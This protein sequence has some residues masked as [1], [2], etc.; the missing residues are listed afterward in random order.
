M[1][2][3]RIAYDWPEPWAGLA[4]HPYE[5][6]VAQAKRGHEITVFAGK[7]PKS[8]HM[9]VPEGVTVKGFIREPVKGSLAFT[10]SLLLF[11]YYLNWRR[12]N[13]PDLIHI[14]GHFA[15]WILGYRRL[16]RKLHPS[17][18]ELTIPLVAHFHNTVEGRKRKLQAKGSTISWV[19]KYISWPLA[20]RSDK[21]AIQEANAYIFVSE[22]LKNEAIEFYG[23]D[24]VKCF[25]I[26]TGVN[27]SL[28][29]LVSGEEKEKTR[30][31]L[32]LDIEDI[33]LLN[34]GMQV[35]RKNTLN[36]VL[37]LNHLPPHYKVM[38]IGPGDSEYLT[39]IDDAIANNNLQG[40]VIRGGYMPYPQM[41]IALQADDV[42]VLHS[43]F[44]GLPK[45]VL[46]A[47]SCGVPVLASGFKIQDQVSGLA[48]LPDTSPEAIASAVTQL[49][50]DPP[51]VDR[52]YVRLHYSWDTRASELDS[53]YNQ[54]LRH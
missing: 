41:P 8:G 19:S 38:L 36:L 50:A 47:L 2:I 28:F 6:T 53:V 35:R 44:E 45:A 33:V 26:R 25:V 49:L 9:L 27:V 15:L 23:A 24:P 29:K 54:L 13:R 39:E 3:L 46:E 40:R 18:A 1:K 21:W 34:Y 14:H 5:L 31:D 22:G 4:P 48:Y 52:T 30:R 7:W 32:G 10:T 43:S 51:N 16:L 42:L 37:A 11:V 12:T 17:S 20:L